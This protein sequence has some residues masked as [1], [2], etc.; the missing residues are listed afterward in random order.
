M[1]LEANGLRVSYG[2]VE[3]IHGIDFSISEGKTM[4]LLG[5]NGAGKT[6]LLMGL[7]GFIPTKGVIKL[8]STRIDG[9]KPYERAKLGLAMVSEQGIFPSLT[10]KENLEV[11]GNSLPRN[12]I[13]KKIRHVVSTFPDIGGKIKQKA[14]ELSGGQRKMLAIA[15]AYMVS[16]KLLLVDEPSLGLSPL[17]VEKVKEVLLQLKRSGIT[18]L[19]AEQNPSFVELADKVIVMDTGSIVF[20]GST[21]EAISNDK[22]R[23]AFFGIE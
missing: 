17:F 8:E 2:D 13:E 1:L 7:M 20:Q 19:I 6:S 12:E 18:M 16:P 4:V 14:L 15:M 9:L 11:A 5:L 22:I 23:K 10:V 3:V 21:E